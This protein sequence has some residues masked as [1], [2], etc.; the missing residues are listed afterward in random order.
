[1]QGKQRWRDEAGICGSFARAPAFEARLVGALP[2]AAQ[3]NVGVDAKL[4][5]LE[6]AQD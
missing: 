2:G 3:V 1:M 5:E 6:G 4:E